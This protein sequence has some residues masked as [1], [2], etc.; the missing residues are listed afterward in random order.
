VVNV[1]ARNATGTSDCRTGAASLDLPLSSGIYLTGDLLDGGAADRPEIAGIQPCPLCTDGTCKGGPNHGAPCEPGSTTLG[2]RA[3]YPTSHDCPPP[4]AAFLGNL[5][6]P[7]ALSTEPQGLEAFDNLP[8][9]ANVF[10]GF[11]GT[12]VGFSRTPRARAART[13]SAPS[14]SSGSAGRRTPERSARTWRALRPRAP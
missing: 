8:T 13:R 2:G 7:F 6:I 4:D 1:V 12:A 9:Q 11:C 5:P 14:V 10:C 3:E